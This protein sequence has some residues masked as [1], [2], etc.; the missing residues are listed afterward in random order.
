MCDEFAQV[1]SCSLTTGQYLGIPGGG[2]RPP[3]PSVPSVP[4]SWQQYADGNALPEL[5]PWHIQ[6]QPPGH[7]GL[8]AVVGPFVQP[9]VAAVQYGPMPHSLRLRQSDRDILKH[10]DCDGSSVQGFY[11]DQKEAYAIRDRHMTMRGSLNLCS[12]LPV[13]EGTRLH[14]LS[15]IWTTTWPTAHSSK[16]VPASYVGILDHDVARPAGRWHIIALQD[17]LDHLQHDRLARQFHISHFAGCP[18]FF[19]KHT[20]DSDLGVSSVCIH[21]VDMK[22]QVEEGGR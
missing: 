1:Q 8:P 6:L 17:A 19:G 2:M 20:F 10:Y 9:A 5:D 4:K 11:T 7:G 15:T 18:V 16:P 14:S 12:K 22:R 3:P 21:D 13:K